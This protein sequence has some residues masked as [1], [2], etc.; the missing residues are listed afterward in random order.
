MPSII[1]L[2][3]RRLEEVGE[4]ENAREKETRASPLR[5][6]VLS[7]ATTSKRLLRRLFIIGVREQLTVEPLC[8]ETSLLRTVSKSR[9]NSH[10]FSF[11]KTL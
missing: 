5:A 6:P 11:K 8:T 1:S 9:Q 4:K 10:I 2:R 3:S 7:F